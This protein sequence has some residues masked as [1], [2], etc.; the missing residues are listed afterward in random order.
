MCCIV[1]WKRKAARS[2]YAKPSPFS[3]RDYAEQ[4]REKR[5]ASPS[6][7][8]GKSDGKAQL[9]T[10]EKSGDVLNAPTMYYALNSKT[11]HC[12]PC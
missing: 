9:F 11:H 3:D 2:R 7:F 8:S 5:E 6:S 1:T 12:H 4:S 10:I